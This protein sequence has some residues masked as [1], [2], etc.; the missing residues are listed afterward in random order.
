MTNSLLEVF[1]DFEEMDRE[2]FYKLY[3][4][5]RNYYNFF[6][7]TSKTDIEARMMAFDYALKDTTD[8][9]FFREQMKYR[10]IDMKECYTE[11]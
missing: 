1:G 9:M 8:L 7:K 3:M 6:I 4:N 5:I 10:N 2:H 11:Y